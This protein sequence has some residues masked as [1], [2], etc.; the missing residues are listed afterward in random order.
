MSTLLSNSLLCGISI[1]SCV[2]LSILHEDEECMVIIL[3]STASLWTWSYQCSSVL[4]PLLPL[5][6]EEQRRTVTSPGAGRE[7]RSRQTGEPELLGCKGCWNQLHCLLF[8]QK[9]RPKS[10][11]NKEL[12]CVH[13]SSKMET[14]H[15][16]SVLT[17]WPLADHMTD[18]A[19]GCWPCL[20]GFLS[21]C[22]PL[23]T[24]VMTSDG[25]YLLDLSL[26]VLVLKTE[27][28]L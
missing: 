18:R 23:S 4:P 17:S 19:G 24:S 7:Q 9:R 10:K 14:C 6:G 25:W 28:G 16:V 8:S 22:F 15:R 5:S 26:G 12:A 1:P 11:D 2:F 20:S 13:F 27:S 21:H 3:G